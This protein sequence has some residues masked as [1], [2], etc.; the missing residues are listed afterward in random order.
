MNHKNRRDKDRKD[1][2]RRKP[3]QEFPDD[4]DATYYHNEAVQLNKEIDLL[5]YIVHKTIIDSITLRLKTHKQYP[6]SLM[7][8]FT[9]DFETKEYSNFAWAV[10]REELMERGFVAEFEF[11][12]SKESEL[13]NSEST[14]EK[15]TSIDTLSDLLIGKK[16]DA[17]QVNSPENDESIFRTMGILKFLHVTIMRKLALTG[18]LQSYVS[19]EES[20][21]EQESN[22]NSDSEEE[23]DRNVHDRKARKLGR[24]RGSFPPPSNID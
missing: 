22:N 12:E 2:D 20:D 18:P 8:T 4:F 15:K 24:K 16:S 3:L 11:D 10:I 7:D 23:E 5:R 1:S 6:L 14:D 9:V 19:D 13:K 17:Y 21:N